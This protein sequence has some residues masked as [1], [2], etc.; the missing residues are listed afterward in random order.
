MGVLGRGR[1]RAA[2]GERDLR[3]GRRLARVDARAPGRGGSRRCRSW[4]GFVARD[5]RL[6][7]LGRA[8]RHRDLGA[9]DEA[10]VGVAHDH[11]VV[12]LRGEHPDELPLGQVGVLELVD[13]HVA[14]P[15]PPPVQRVGVLAEELHDEQEQVVEVGRRGLGQ[16]LL[17]LDVD[18]GQPLLG[19]GRR[20]RE[21]FLRADELVL[22]RGD[23][24]LQLAGREPLGIEVDVAAD[25]VDETR[26]VGLVVDRERRPVAEQ[27]GFAAQDARARGV[28]G[29]DPHAVRDGTDEL[30]DALLHLARGLVRERDREDLEWRHAA[31]RDQVRDPVGE[32]AGLAR[33]CARDHEH[34]TVGRDHRLALHGVQPGDEIV[35]H[36]PELGLRARHR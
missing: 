11:H 7:R 9:G 6:D 33:P 14:E 16:P 29:R 8:I 13:E 1:E 4:R 23:R 35:A 31:F 26:G 22:H 34:R 17:V 19:R 12:V 15:L 27:A 3:A 25:V 2:A 30:G 18:L 5:H 36:P 10:L 28:E 20:T 32:E 21:R 24:A